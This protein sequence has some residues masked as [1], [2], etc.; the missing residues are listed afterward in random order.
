MSVFSFCSA[1][2]PRDNVAMEPRKID[3]FIF[4]WFLWVFWESEGII[5]MPFYR[6]YHVNG[7]FIFG[8][9]C[10]VSG[11]VRGN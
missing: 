1:S 7:V 2:H 9:F 6:G 11:K 3:V 8:G 4:L 10:S 5:K